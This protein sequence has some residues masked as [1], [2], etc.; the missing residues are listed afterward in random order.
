MPD[1]AV[2]Q[3]LL[4]AVSI[5]ADGSASRTLQ[6][7]ERCKIVVLGIASGQEIP[8]QAGTPTTLQVVKGDVRLTLDGEEK[9]LSTGAWV[10][11]ASNVRYT[12]YARTDLLLL[13]TVL[14]K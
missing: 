2:I 8:Q 11:M 7:D 14:T 3:D 4:T 10:F 1:R 5:P 6:Q 13:L 12:I 9:E